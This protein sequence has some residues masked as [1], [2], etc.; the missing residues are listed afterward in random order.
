MQT[1]RILIVEDDRLV[2]YS[3][4]VVLEEYYDVVMAQSCEEAWQLLEKEAFSVVLSD[5][6]M[7]G[8]NGFELLHRIKEIY[9][10]I[11]VIMLSGY[12][13][14]QRLKRVMDEGAFA[15]L[16]KPID[17]RLLIQTINDALGVS[18]E[19]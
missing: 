1:P 15:Y 10:Y 18:A 14:E 9:P 12:V 6:M 4:A 17:D 19:T 8:M 7:Q 16:I 5:I 2:L 3:L 11:S 13:S